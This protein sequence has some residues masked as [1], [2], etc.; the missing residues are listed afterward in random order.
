MRAYPLF[1]QAMNV[2]PTYGLAGNIEIFENYWSREECASIIETTNLVCDDPQSGF[3]WDKATTIGQGHD[4]QARTNWH[5]GVT[6]AM[7]VYGN[8]Y[9]K[10]L[11]N[12]MNDLLVDAGTSYCLRQGI[13]EH[14]WQEGYNMLK[15]SSGEE[16]KVHYDGATETGRHVSAILYLNDEYEGGEIEF[17]AFKIKIKPQAGMLIMFP[18]NF[19]YRHVAHPVISGTKY[20]M[21]TWLHDREV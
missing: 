12:K 9:M 11:H 8:E 4:Q 10:H 18:S 21:V 13:N 20:A 3:C 5:L 16:Y 6:H 19:A 14:F 1:R 7:Q 2:L 17:P 15:Y